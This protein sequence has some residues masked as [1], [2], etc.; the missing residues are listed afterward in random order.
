[1]VTQKSML[2]MRRVDFEVRD[3]RKVDQDDC[4][5]W[6]LAYRRELAAVNST[7]HGGTIGRA[8]QGHGQPG[9]PSSVGDLVDPQDGD[10]GVSVN[11]G[12]RATCGGAC[13][14]LSTDS[15]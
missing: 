7:G 11:Q 3:A 6:Q 8:A 15:G 13:G 2:C 1:M 14:G 12:V 10:L 9:Q 5:S 4:R